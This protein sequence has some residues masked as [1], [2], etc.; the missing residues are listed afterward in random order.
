VCANQIELHHSWSADES[1]FGYA[2]RIETVIQYAPLEYSA[3][4]PSS[5][6]MMVMP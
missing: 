3:D 5:Y 4:D 1:P 2:C 6:M